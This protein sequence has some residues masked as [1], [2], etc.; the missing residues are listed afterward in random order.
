MQTVTIDPLHPPTGD[1]PDDAPSAGGLIWLDSFEAHHPGSLRLYWEDV[2]GWSCSR[3]ANEQAA[4]AWSPLAYATTHTRILAWHWQQFR[5]KHGMKAF[6]RGPTKR[7]HGVP[8]E[9]WDQA[10]SNGHEPT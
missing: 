10:I 5:L 9:I 7:R 4:V 8:V 1:V 6:T 2:L 3:E